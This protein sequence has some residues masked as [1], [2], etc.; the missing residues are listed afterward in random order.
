MKYN[1]RKL[2]YQDCFLLPIAKHVLQSNLHD[3]CIDHFVGCKCGPDALPV[4]IF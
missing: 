1:Q 2:L 3:G 4:L